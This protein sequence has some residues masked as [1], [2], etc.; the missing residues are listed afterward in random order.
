MDCYFEA[1][2]T[3]HIIRIKICSI[4]GL[5]E[6]MV[7]NIVISWGVLF[8]VLCWQQRRRMISPPALNHPLTP[9]MYSLSKQ[10][11][12][13]SPCPS[14]GEYYDS[15]ATCNLKHLQLFRVPILTWTKLYWVVFILYYNNRWVVSNKITDIMMSDYTARMELLIC[16]PTS[17]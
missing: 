17:N 8:V 6:A 16:V 1:K 4:S 11:V 15:F 9:L 2:G 14:W 7:E 10:L 12:P 5:R 3:F 13:L